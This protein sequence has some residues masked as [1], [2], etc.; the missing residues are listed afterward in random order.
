MTESRA[1][2]V[3]QAHSADVVLGPNNVLSGIELAVRA[4]E[5]VAVVGPNGSG[6]STLL[7]LLAGL[8]TPSIGHVTVCGTRSNLVPRRELAKQIAY[9]QQ[10]L[11]IQFPLSCIEAVLLGRSPHKRGLGLADRSDIEWASKVMDELEVSNLAQRPVTA[12]SG[13]ELQRLMFGRVLLQ[14]AMFSLLDEPTSAQDPRGQQLI[15]EGIQTLIDDG[16]GGVAA[17]HDLNFA[18]AHFDRIWVIHEGR[19]IAEGKPA[20]VLT[21]KTLE[22][23][24]R[25][26]FQTVDDGERKLISTISRV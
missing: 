9:M 4:G 25:V 10:K 2:E 19:V 23:A 21:S 11:S 7:R 8:I 24:F 26:S 15:A 6:K 3:L 18:L 13:G 17:V 14:D 5:S 12:V 16:K 22:R 1:S 20:D